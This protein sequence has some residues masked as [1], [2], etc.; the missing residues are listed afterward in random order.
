MLLLDQTTWR[1]TFKLHP[2][3]AYSSTFR[4][5]RAGESHSHTPQSCPGIG[6][7]RRSLGPSEEPKRSQFI[8]W[9]SCVPG[10]SR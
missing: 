1:G 4:V 5:H 9:Y 6:A 8:M 3:H 2:T 7:S 10:F